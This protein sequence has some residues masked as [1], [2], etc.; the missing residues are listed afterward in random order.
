[1]LAET[2]IFAQ[3]GTESFRTVEFDL[4]QSTPGI[5]ILVLG[6][7]LLFTL[8]FWTSLRDSRFLKPAWRVVLLL[9]RVTALVLVLAVLLNPRER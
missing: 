8:T 3:A 9:L 4:P 6:L 2:Y 7:T 5:L 1:M